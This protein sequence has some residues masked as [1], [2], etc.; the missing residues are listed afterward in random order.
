MAQTAGEWKAFFLDSGIP[1]T[2]ADTYADTFVQ[3]RINDAADLTNEL[4]K[5]M[6][7]TVVGDVIAILKQAK[8]G[9]GP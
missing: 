6:K 8:K 2:E 7:K 3:N 1:E 5:Q 9:S 4:L